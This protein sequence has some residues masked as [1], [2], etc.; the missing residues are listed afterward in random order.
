LD[1]F[2]IRNPPFQTGLSGGSQNSQSLIYMITGPI[3][4]RSN[5]RVPSEGEL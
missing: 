1:I 3:L 2:I 4:A 5:S